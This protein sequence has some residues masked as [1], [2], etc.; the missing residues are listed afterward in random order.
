MRTCT[1]VHVSTAKNRNNTGLGKKR[2]GDANARR[3]RV[4]ETGNADM[5]ALQRRQ[6]ASRNMSAIQ[7]DG[8]R[9]VIPD[10][11]YADVTE[12]KAGDDEE[13]ECDN[14]K[15][16]NGFEHALKARCAISQLSHQTPV[17][18]DR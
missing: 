5:R 11:R 8:G 12:Y 16:D 9:L 18:S 6:R 15:N 4:D 1:P 10:Q 14:Q 7:Y 3:H 2:H 17:G 13:R